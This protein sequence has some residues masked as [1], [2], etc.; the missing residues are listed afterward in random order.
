MSPWG[1]P[2]LFVRKKDGT[3]R[4]CIDFRQL[5]KATVKNKCPLPRIDDLFDQLR[6]VKI[7]SKIDLRSGYHQVRIKEEGISKTAFRT[8][9]GHY[10]FMV[11]PFRLIN[12]P[13]T[14]IC[15]MNGIFR[16]YLDKFVIMFLDDILIYSKSEK[17]MR[18]I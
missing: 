11:V 9:Y 17:N 4:L 6:G 8:R 3:L 7:L 1:A 2:V 18:S 14:F 13:T 5:N 12:A 16:K 15:L 10:E